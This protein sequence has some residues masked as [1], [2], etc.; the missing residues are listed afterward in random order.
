MP[1]RDTSEVSEEKVNIK[2]MQICKYIQ[3]TKDEESQDNNLELTFFR[4]TRK[5]FM[6]ERSYMNSSRAS[7][8]SPHLHEA[9]LIAVVD[10]VFIL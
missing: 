10:G 5:T 1:R 3:N 8:R 9:I 2:R 6:K 4:G 7:S